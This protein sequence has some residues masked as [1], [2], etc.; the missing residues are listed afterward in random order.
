[1]G[2]PSPS[3]SRHV[4]RRC[5]EAQHSI[6]ATERG[7]G[8]QERSWSPACGSACSP[9]CQHTES[10]SVSGL[11]RA[12]CLLCQPAGRAEGRGRGGCSGAGCC[13]VGQQR[14]TALAAG[15]CC[16][17][18]GTVA[19]L[20]VPGQGAATSGERGTWVGGQQGRV[21]P[22]RGVL[23][24]RGTAGDGLEEQQAACCQLGRHKGTSRGAAGM[25]ATGSEW[26]RGRVLH[27]RGT[28]CCRLWEEDAVA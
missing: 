7:Q 17:I 16:W 1:M 4:Q 12:G 3:H 15:G 24:A 28:G 11:Q 2:H 13:P 8:Q 5:T 19:W 10:C 27:S 21:L 22:V 20:G 26:Q 23:P 25:G 14:G 6:L 18:G 9:P